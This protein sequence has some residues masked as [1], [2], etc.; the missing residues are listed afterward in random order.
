MEWLCQEARVIPRADPQKDGNILCL[1]AHCTDEVTMI[2]VRSMISRI[3]GPP[4]TNSVLTGALSRTITGRII[5]NHCS[6]SDHQPLSKSQWTHVY[7][8]ALNNY[9]DRGCR[10][11]WAFGIITDSL[12]MSQADW[13]VDNHCSE[14]GDLTV[15]N[16][17]SWK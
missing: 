3:G 17:T 4:G 8:L 13:F 16:S 15:R 10:I 9:L 1:W 2:T 11:Q 6:V 7:Q 14:I 12:L 5:S